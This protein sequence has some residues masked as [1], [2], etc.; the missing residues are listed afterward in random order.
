L[1]RIINVV[2]ARPNFIKIAPIME[3]YKAHPSVQPLLVHTGQH[4]DEAMNDVFFRELAI[5]RPDVHL[6]IPRGGRAARIAAIVAAF[7]EVLR[8]HKPDAVVVVGDCDSAAACA[9][10]AVRRGVK[11]AHVEAGLRSFDRSMPEENNRILVDALADLLLCTEQSALDN[12]EAEGIDHDKVHLVGNVMIDTLLAWRDR[13]G[14]SDVLDRLELDG[15]AYAVLTLHRMGNVD[16][17]A[18]LSRLFD[19]IERIAAEMPVVFPVH[20]RTQ[21]RFEQFGLA[22]RLEAMTGLRQTEPLG[23]LDF[24]KLMDNA[25]LV[26]T[27]SGG[28]QEETTVLGVPCLTLRNNTERPATVQMGTNRLVGTDPAAILDGYKNVL[29]GGIQ[30]Q[31]PPPLWD[32]R[33]AGR[34]AELL[35]GWA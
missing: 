35:A 9:V 34:I 29:A 3:A 23:Y 6:G 32:G 16:A 11:L 30:P 19:A 25:K 20:P 27:D 10:A 18:V 17:P 15:R 7:D 22:R 5:R 4:Y 2:G 1:S 8:R 14:R 31:G 24:V 13:A 21:V 33:A 28:I 26:L 12:L